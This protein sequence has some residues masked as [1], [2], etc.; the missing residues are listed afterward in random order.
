MQFLPRRLGFLGIADVSAATLDAVPQFPL[1]DLAAVLE[2]DRQGRA[3]ATDILARL[4]AAS[5]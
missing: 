1:P 2:A 3:A 4:Q 5:P